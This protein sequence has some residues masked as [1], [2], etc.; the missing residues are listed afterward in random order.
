MIGSCAPTRLRI[1]LGGV[2]ALWLGISSAVLADAPPRAAGPVASQS[3]LAT[4][5]SAEIAAAAAEQN[6]VVPAAFS[7]EPHA[8]E[9]SVGYDRGF[10]IAA[11]SGNVDAS[12]DF[13]MR[14][15]SWS[16][17]RHTYFESDGTNPDENSFSFERL[18][19]SFSGHAFSPALR[20]FMQLDA[21][22]DRATDAIFLDYFLAYD[23]GKDLFGWQSRRLGVKVGKWKMPFSRSREES[24][25]RLQFTD[26]ATANVFFDLNRSIGVGLFGEADLCD[27]PFVFETA[28]FNGIRTGGADTT[29][30][31]GLDRNFGWSIRSHTDFLSPF[32]N[33]GEPDLKPHETPTLRLGAGAATTRVDA[34]G[35]TEFSRQPAVDSGTPVSM[36]LPP[37]VDAYDVWLAT[38]DAHFKYQG[39]AFIAE[40][41]WRSLANFNGAAVPSTF[42]HGYNLQTGYFI[43][44]ERVELLARWSRI[45]GDS[46]TLG[47]S[48]ESSD[49]V[50]GGLVW[51][52]KGHNAKLT[53]DLTHLNGAPIRSDRLDTLG[54]DRGWL[55]RTQL[56]VAF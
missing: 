55:L 1:L 54:G 10:V 52:I 21:N 4:A 45:V 27:Q 7:W 23:L 53:T 15:N 29:R 11:D 35:A 41:Y 5:G 37:E 42:D 2:C 39:F 28:L 16:Q 6:E 14:V 44:P 22:S 25:R 38:V 56:Q 36:L 46:G 12:D 17:L 48:V 49:E 9:F 8:L 34:E 50:A 3:S 30:D 47:A 31:A 26:R 20:Y 32:G 19:L 51:Y 18:R 33:S 13:L 40:Y 43:Y 24:G